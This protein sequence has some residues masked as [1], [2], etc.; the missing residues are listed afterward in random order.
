VEEDVDAGH[1]ERI[2]VVDQGLVHNVRKALEGQEFFASVHEHRSS[3]IAHSLDIAEVW[4]V[5][6]VGCQNVLQGLVEFLT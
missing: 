2:E 3:D 5:D 6:A 4:P 1:V